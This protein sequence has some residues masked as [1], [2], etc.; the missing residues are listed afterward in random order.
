MNIVKDNIYLTTRHP[1]SVSCLLPLLCFSSLTIGEETEGVTV[2]GFQ[3]EAER[4]Q[5]KFASIST[6]LNDY[7]GTW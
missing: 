6:P 5:K 4:I 1:Y 3:D 2:V 7:F